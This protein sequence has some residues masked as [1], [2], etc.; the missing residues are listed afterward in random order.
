MS[1]QL[2]RLSLKA[3]LFRGLGDST[4]LSILDTQEVIR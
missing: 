4:K 1:I 3:K 2:Q